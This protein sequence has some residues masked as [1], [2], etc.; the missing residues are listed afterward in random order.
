MQWLIDIIQEWLQLNHGY[1]DR[2]NT[3]A[4]DF[5]VGDFT[6]DNQWH[7]LVLPACVPDD[8]RAVTIFVRLRA[9][10]VNR[11][12]LFK[13]FD[14]PNDFNYTGFWTQVANLRVGCPFDIAMDSPSR[15]IRY[16]MSATNLTEVD[17]VV[18][19][20]WL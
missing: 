14:Y 13:P 7:D 16:L 12:I 4:Y 20:W 5:Q 17:F 6:K 18:K 8:A 15:K 10:A 1:F 19:G 3:A 11:A 9:S 2:G